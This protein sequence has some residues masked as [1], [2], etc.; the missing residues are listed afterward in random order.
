MAISRWGIV[1]AII[2]MIN[3]LNIR[4]ETKLTCECLCLL[5]VYT[6]F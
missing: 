5:Y 4:F 2:F 1:D 3:K 6:V